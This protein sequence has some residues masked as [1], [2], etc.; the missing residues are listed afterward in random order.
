VASISHVNEVPSAGEIQR[1]INQMSNRKSPVIDGTPADVFKLC[2]ASL[3]PHLVDLTELIWKEAAV[4]Q[5]F[6]DAVIVH[7]YKRKEDRSRCDTH[8]GSRYSRLHTKFFNR[9]RNHVA[10]YD[11]S[12]RPDVVFEH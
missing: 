1:A 9:L 3:L 2:T 10:Q 6:K 8:R 12:Q 4:P 11:T 5:D 7:T